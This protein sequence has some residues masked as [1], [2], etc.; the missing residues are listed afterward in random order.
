[1]KAFTRRGILQAG[2][3][4]GVALMAGSRFAAAQEKSLKIAWNGWPEDQVKPL[5]DGFEAANKGIKANYE[6]IPFAQ[7]FQTLEVRLSART[8]E[9]DI[10]SVDS[11][12]TASYAVRGHVEALDDM[13]DR[14]RFS[15]AAL[16]AA[17]FRG[18]LYSAPFA[19]SGQALFF[20][21]AHFKAAGIEPP[22]TDVNDRWTW[23][24]VVAAA[25]KMS[26]PAQN[27]WGLVIEQA[28]RPYQLLPFA[29]SLGGQAISEDGLKASGFIDS[30]AF[31]EGYTF[32]QRLYTDW[33]VSPPGMFDNSLTPELFSSGK[34]AMFLGG[35][36]NF[37]N[38]AKRLGPD[39][40]VAAHPYFEK[41][42][43]VT[44]TGSWHIGVNPRTRNKAEVTRFIQYMLS[45]DVQVEWFK[46]RPY[47]PVLRN[48]WDKMAST[49]NTP[50][51][52]LIRYEVDNTAVPRPATPGFREYEDILRVALRDM[53]QP[54]ADVKTL[55]TQ[56]AQKIDR[57]LQKYR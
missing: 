19:S 44:P 15:K 17:S 24:K 12:L 9:P 50:E 3:A 43:P 49:F 30:P 1:M 14:S 28:E 25:Q 16:D 5:M 10:Y 33:K 38:F 40:G 54:G 13:I 31:V 36:F 45:D 26:N 47:V 6:R 11:P 41:G 21:R 27:Q 52:K 29:Q 42:K 34:T 32:M 56:A 37:D 39:Y 7:F 8:P 20:N 55:L 53:Q 57:E 2:G 51:W 18:K 22:K 4:A 48:V 35:T 23:E 46:L